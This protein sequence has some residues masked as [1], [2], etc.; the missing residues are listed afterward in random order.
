[1][2]KR[3][4]VRE[5]VESFM[6]TTLQA[7]YPNMSSRWMKHSCIKEN[8]NRQTQVCYITREESVH[9]HCVFEKGESFAKSFTTD[10]GTVPL[11]RV[12]SSVKINE[13]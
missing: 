13:Q 1:M 12:P 3:K 8:A 9:E 4:T 10:R 2:I 7:T 11:F 5:T 6:R